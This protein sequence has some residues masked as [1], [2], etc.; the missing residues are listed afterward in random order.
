MFA[1]VWLQSRYD[2]DASRY[3]VH[4]S[5]TSTAPLTDTL[6]LHLILPMQLHT[7]SSDD[8]GLPLIFWLS[9]T[10][11]VRSQTAYTATIFINRDSRLL[12][13]NTDREL[14]SPKLPLMLLNGTSRPVQLYVR[15]APIAED[16]LTTQAL[17]TAT[18][19]LSPALGLVRF[20]PPSAAIMLETPAE[21]SERVFWQRAI[22][23]FALPLSFATGLA[24][25]ALTWQNRDQQAAE[26][27]DKDLRE[28]QA[29][30]DQMRRR[31]AQRQSLLE[32]RS[33]SSDKI[34]AIIDD[35]LRVR[36][37]AENELWE[38]TVVDELR[39]EIA[40]LSA[41]PLY[42]ETVLLAV[43]DL[44]RVQESAAR[45]LAQGQQFFGDEFGRS[46]GILE[47]ALYQNSGDGEAIRAALLWLWERYP[48]KMKELA[49]RTIHWL[50]EHAPTIK[51]PWERLR[52]RS[53]LYHPLLQDLVPG[54]QSM[55]SYLRTYAWPKQRRVMLPDDPPALQRWMKQRD[56][57]TNPFGFGVLTMDPLLDRSWNE[58]SEWEQM[59]AHRSMVIT[60]A[61]G[62]DRLVTGMML[63]RTYEETFQQGILPVWLTLP[64]N[65]V[66]TRSLEDD[67]LRVIT[68]VIGEACIRLVALNPDALLDLPA[69]DL[70]ILAEHMVWSAGSQAAL[71]LWL[72]QEQVLEDAATMLARRIEHALGATK[73]PDSPSR[74]R[75]LT[76]LHVRPARLQRTCIFVDCRPTAEN[77]GHAQAET[78]ARM[79]DELLSTGVILKLL[80]A[81]PLGL[82]A[83]QIDV[84]PLAWSD[85]ALGA[86][87]SARLQQSAPDA[88]FMRFGQLFGPGRTDEPENRLVAAAGGSLSRLLALGRAT[89]ERHARL[90]PDEAYL[91]LD[92]LAEA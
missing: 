22:S 18:V 46:L 34:L 58:P 56:I 79:A 23:D 78:L 20:N 9:D 1:A 2:F 85:S 4:R 19:Q 10:D 83:G 11:S 33:Q 61:E 16:N 71:N 36:D 13:T 21:T 75:L 42:R 64:L 72:R 90:R 48:D 66:W 76:W 27:R 40:A 55:A 81:A 62:Q 80:L 24:A 3:A 5:L 28:R 29:A 59:C 60:A 54:D 50:H 84:V 70:A 67:L 8:I 12:L 38:T 82:P 43:D 6:T 31:Q 74:D 35:C 49:A 17:L 47:T 92:E 30:E 53:L 89:L 25:L 57:T 86:T 91:D 37:R 14:V 69:A 77:A 41:Q 15:P 51:I 39:E 52:L 87:L 65:E 26:A 7:V 44:L 63:Q 68:H 73:P 45:L 32:L 88:R